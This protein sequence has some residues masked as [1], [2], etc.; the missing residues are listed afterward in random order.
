MTDDELL[1]AQVRLGDE[2]LR[3]EVGD[4]LILLDLETEAYYGLNTIARA[5][6][7]GVSNGDVPA[8]VASAIAAEHG[9]NEE[10]VR[11]DMAGLLRELLDA[12]LVD[13]VPS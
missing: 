7:E 13:V 3:R 1:L 10:R 4:E 8:T 2:V 9:E 11:E 6:I 12:G 5:F